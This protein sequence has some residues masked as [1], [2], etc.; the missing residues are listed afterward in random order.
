[1]PTRT[2]SG[3]AR[4]A[5]QKFIRGL[6]A[7]RRRP[8]RASS[9][10]IRAA[11]IAQAALETGW[12]TLAARR[13]DGASH[14]LFGIKAGASWN[15]ASVQC[16]HHGI[17][18][19]RRRH[20]S[21]AQLSRLRVAAE[22]VEDYVRADARQPALR[23]GAEHR[24]R[25]A[26]RLRTR[27]SAAVTPPIRTTPTS[28]PRLPRRSAAN[29]LPRMTVQ[30]GFRRADSGAGPAEDEQWLTALGRG[31]PVCAPLQRA[32][33]TTSHNIANVSTEGY[34]R[35][36]VE[37]ADAH[38]AGLRRQLDRHRRRRRRPCAASTTSSSRSRPA[39]PAAQPR[40][41]RRVRLA[42]R[43]HRQPAR[44]QRQRTRRLAAELH[45]RDQ[46]SFQHA[47]LDSGAPGAARRR[48]ARWPSACKSYDARLRDMS[49]EVDAPARRRSA[50]RSPRSRRASRKLNGDITAAIQQTGQPPNDLLDQRD[51]AH[52]PAVGA[53]SASPW[54][55][56]A[57]RRST[58]SSATASRWCSA[59]RPR[60]SPR[61]RIRSI[62]SALQ[63]ALQTPRRHRRHFAQRLRRHA[64]RPARLAQP[65]ARSGAQ[66][67]RPHHAR[68]RLRR[69]TRSIARAWTSP[70]RWAA[71]SSTS[72]R[73]GVTTATTNTG[74]A[75][76]TAT[77]TNLGALT[78]N[79]YVLARTGT[80]YTLRRQDTGAASP[81]PAPAPARDPILCRRPVHRRGR[82]HRHRRPVRRFIRRAMPSR[83]SAW[84]SPIRRRSPRRRRS[85]PPPPAPTPAPAPCHA[86]EVLDPTN[87][88]L[89]TTVNIVFTSATTYSVN[90]GPKLH[91]HGRLDHRRQRLARADQRRTGH[92]R[93]ASP[94]AATPAPSATIAM[95]SRWPMP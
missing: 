39:A 35:Q 46:R 8:R 32:L 22:S 6:P 83:A 31:C 66:R 52:R 53:R 95:R 44:R 24:Q 61:P 26:A 73:V 2:D 34:T 88:A 54:S 7:A 56:T 93:H 86:G 37:F 45:R 91:L 50:A 76:V 13:R 27:C 12:G 23:R 49:A 77:R 21:D 78:A 9:A 14:N 20:A 67:A 11:I 16:E 68:R 62:R 70:A 36:R 90:G 65:D 51:T 5:A 29:E 19:G 94:C 15:G 71:T 33:D 69:S 60:R 74:T 43:A 41:A 10:S 58:Y 87:A 47:E 40:A 75:T 17:R 18:R 80:G 81:S 85:A 30:V 42:G 4:E 28:W 48:A 84:R 72:A 92:R 59:P 1:M 82:G 63:L 3:D 25:R 55:P 64:R 38:A 89:L 57:I 79:D